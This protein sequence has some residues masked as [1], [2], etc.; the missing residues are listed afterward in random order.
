[1]PYILTKKHAAHT[2]LTEI[3]RQGSGGPVFNVIS[4][5]YLIIMRYSIVTLVNSFKCVFFLLNKILSII[6]FS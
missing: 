5:R 2:F 3:A 1:M 6:I 4:S